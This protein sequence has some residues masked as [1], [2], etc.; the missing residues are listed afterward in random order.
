MNKTIADI[1]NIIRSQQTISKA[2]CKTLA[3]IDE[4][5]RISLENKRNSSSEAE[6]RNSALSH[7]QSGSEKEQLAQEILQTQRKMTNE[8]S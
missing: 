2:D 5:P 6:T 8:T 4:F 1:E 7:L 3:P